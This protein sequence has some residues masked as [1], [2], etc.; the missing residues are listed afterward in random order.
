MKRPGTR[1]SPAVPK[2]CLLHFPFT[3]RLGYNRANAHPSPDE[4]S[5][6]LQWDLGQAYSSWNQAIVLEG[7]KEGKTVQQC[8][9]GQ[10]QEMD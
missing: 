1:R 5:H 10:I 4:I 6:G 2:L 8:V 3:A 9:L 7:G